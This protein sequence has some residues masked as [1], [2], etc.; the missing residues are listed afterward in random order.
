MAAKV[1]TTQ[2]NIQTETVA[3]NLTI[4]RTYN[5]APGV[6]A[7][8]DPIYYI[9]LSYGDNEFLVDSEGKRTRLISQGLNGKN[10]FLTNEQVGTLFMTPIKKADGTDTVLGEL[11][12]ELMDAVIVEDLNKPVT[13]NQLP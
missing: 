8:I 11:L 7:G 12:A 13:P 10:I 3:H 6:P 9:G 5:V 4:S 1:V 2:S